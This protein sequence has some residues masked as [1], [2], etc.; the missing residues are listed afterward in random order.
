MRIIGIDPGTAI[1]GWGIIEADGSDLSMVAYGAFTTPAKQPLPDRLVS[2]YNDL[3]HVLAEYRPVVA[4][5][6]ELFF[7]KN[8]TTAMAVSH[9]RGVALLA[10]R[11]AKLPIFEYKPLSV[12]QAVVGYGNA[13]KKQMQHLVQMTLNLDHI[14][15][16]DDAADALAVAMCHAYAAPY[17][18]RIQEDS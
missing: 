17:L 3:A 4:A 15:K 6:E 5:V 2:I 14:P 1:M 16:P 18:N 9:A 10:L 7:A 13:D 11:Q 12:K 8:V